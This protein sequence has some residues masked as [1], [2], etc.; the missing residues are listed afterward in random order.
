M[1]SAVSV[2]HDCATAP[3]R[4]IDLTHLNGEAVRI[5]HLQTATLGASYVIVNMATDM[6][7]V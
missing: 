4:I 5:N 2:V 7:F 1:D 6:S 3:Y